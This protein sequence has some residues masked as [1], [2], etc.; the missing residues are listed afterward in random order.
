MSPENIRTKSATPDTLIQILVRHNNSLVLQ[1]KSLMRPHHRLN[2][3]RMFQQGRPFSCVSKF[4]FNNNMK[5]R[6]PI[7]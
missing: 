4:A 3:R 1:L 2:I 7:T 6:R 5:Y